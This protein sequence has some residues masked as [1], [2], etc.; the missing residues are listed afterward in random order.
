MKNISSYTKR[1]V[2]FGAL[3][4][5]LLLTALMGCKDEEIVHYLGPEVPENAAAVEQMNT[6]IQAMQRL[7]MAKQNGTAITK[8]L[9]TSTAAYT[10]ELAD[11]NTF[12]LNTEIAGIGEGKDPVYTPLF[13]VRKDGSNYYWTLDGDF[14]MVGGQ[15][16]KVASRVAANPV[17]SV[18]QNGYW[19]VSVDGTVTKLDKLE[20]GLLKS[21][22]SR[23]DISKPGMVVFN[24][25]DGTNALD[26]SMNGGGGS[27]DDPVMGNL[28]RPIDRDHPAWIFHIDTWNHADPQ[29]IIDMVPDDI[30]PYVIF[31]ISMSIYHDNKNHPG[32][33]WLVEDGYSVAK[34]W[35]RVCAENNVWCMVQP[36]S[37]GNCHFPDFSSYE[38][39]KGSLYEEF[40][41]DYPTFLGINY[42]EQMW[43]FAPSDDT[44]NPPTVEERLTHW[45]HLLKLTH[46]YGGYLVVSTCGAYW[47]SGVT[48]TA[49][50]KKSPELV[51]A[52]KLYKE[53]F[54]MCEKFTMSQGFH[55]V[56]SMS[57][58]TWLSG[59]A[60]NYGQRFDECGWPVNTDPD[61]DVM[62]W[63]WNGDE[64]FPV[65][66]GA[67]PMI[68]HIML[69]GQ[70]VYD[71]P[72]TITNM[73]CKE[74]GTESAG[75]GYTRR[76]WMFYDQ[77]YNI[78]MD[79]YRKIID[80]TIRI[81][82]RKEVIDRSKLVFINDD[83]RTDGPCCPGYVGPEY[84]YKGL[85]L[86]DEDGTKETQRSY[87]KK[88]GRYPAI[89]IVTELADDR[90]NTFQK[91]YN[92]SNYDNQ[93][94]DLNKKV[95]VFNSLFPA[96]YT[97]NMYAARHENSWVAYNAYKEVRT[98]SIPFKYNTAEKMELAFGKYSVAAIREYSDRVT[99]YLNNFR[100]DRVQTKDVI[101][102]YGSTMQ[103]KCII[104]ERPIAAAAQIRPTHSMTEEWK[105]GVYTL[106]IK[107][108]GALDVEI[109]C[110]GSATDR[111]TEYTRSSIATPAVNTHP[112]T[113]PLQYEAENFEYKNI[114]RIV[115]K[116]AYVETVGYLTG[117][118]GMGFMNFGSKADAAVR[119]EVTGHETANYTI[120]IRYRAETAS[121]NTV[122]LYVNGKKVATPDFATT[123]QAWSVA[124]NVIQ[125]NQGK[126]TIELKAN[127]TAACDL[128][129]DNI[130][131][132]K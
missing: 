17:V 7:V 19:N 45:S 106:T 3:F 40:F 80:G 68:E 70:T 18:D 85:Y 26:V 69:T 90:A 102:I 126:N 50:F 62:D 56:E 74:N 83:T 103:P 86:L 91:K 44:L 53:N 28:R 15:R 55:A 84:L 24:F 97:G 12:K 89:P 129:L 5:G 81:P 20:K 54:I 94:G 2:R 11:G 121:V 127:A 78:S 37:G 58:G 64:K 65:A 79:I 93:F 60:G 10:V 23:V 122:D 101:K 67:L 119:D 118:Q 59:L 33:F 9:E 52:C 100:Y 131:I 46:E 43:G 34:S 125:L 123:G 1:G 113:G 73:V 61:D 77:L 32:M 63:C 112:Y 132:E 6:N 49:Y 110:A 27:E 98:A 36:A 21:N 35:L 75:D 76:K 48:P 120:R 96:E 99:F 72:E 88:T 47:Q 116:E 114:T 22:F 117:Y 13:G 109:Q 8:C 30:K 39:F 41:R 38:Q 115:K 111:L 25:K 130:V 14:L 66:A 16:A 4:V 87:F 105:D 29:A 57:L 108:N 104:S 51:D 124:S 82:S 92:L 128:Y 31:N 95:G 107:H 42:A 71:G